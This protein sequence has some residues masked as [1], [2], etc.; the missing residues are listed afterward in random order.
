[1]SGNKFLYAGIALLVLG[2]GFA[3]GTYAY[4]Q[5]DVTGTVSGTVLAW[6]CSS[7]NAGIGENFTISLGSLY[8]GVNGS[9]TI[10]VAASIDAD[11][12]ITFNNLTNIGGGSHPNLKLYK[13]SVFTPENE[14]TNGTTITGSV[15]GGS[16]DTAT[17][18]F[19]WPYGN[20]A[21]TYSTN[22]PTANIT[23][24]CDQK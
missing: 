15:T 10:T 23:V 8:P 14:I 24:V 7:N 6:E 2:V 13:A 17:F 22:V 11:Y 5:T 1:M 16:S 12:T 4:Y 21:E 20:S 3:I 18:W 9:K 19:D